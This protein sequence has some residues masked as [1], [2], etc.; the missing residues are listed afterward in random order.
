MAAFD[1]LPA[2]QRA[3]LQLLLK[4]GKSYDE[5]STLLRI[6]PDAVRDRARDAIDALGPDDAAV[7]HDRRDEI[8]DFLLGQQGASQRAATREY[9]EG[10][11]PG[12]AWAR[13]VAG[14]LAPVAPDAI[15]EIPADKEEVSEA[16]EALEA[17][18]ERR[19]EVA[20]S[21]KT[22]GIL[23]LVGLA[24]A[25]TFALVLLISGGDDDGDEERAGTSTSATTAGGNTSVLRTA[26]LTP[27]SG[28]SRERA[29]IALVLRQGKQTGLLIQAAGLAPTSQRAAYGLW[30][31]R[32]G[33]QQFLGYINAGVAQD[34]V[35]RSVAGLTVPIAE[36]RQML[37]TRETQEN[38]RSPGTIALQG[39]LRR[40][41]AQEQQT[42]RDALENSGGAPGT[43]TSPE[44]AT[45]G[46]TTTP[47]GG[48]QTTPPAAGTQTTP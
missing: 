11:A 40:P 10:S 38:P 48:G 42:L 27:P 8:A 36:Y 47:Q 6:E 9:L 2:D 31:R 25:L 18:T 34:G 20:K 29:G 30:L 17:R 7:D 5:L 37:L 16:F 3:V 19:K 13:S 21:S 46:G 28:A 12:R 26:T 43:A 4:Q 22:G 32:P 1:S 23:I 39:A 24:V 33:K 35:L 45:G 41:T 14:V 44:G 15:P